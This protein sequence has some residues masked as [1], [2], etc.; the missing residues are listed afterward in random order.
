MTHIP[1]SKAVDLKAQTVEMF[2][3]VILYQ[4]SYFL[5]FQTSR[6]KEMGL[7]IHKR[8]GMGWQGQEKVSAGPRRCL[9]W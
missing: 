1:G 6:D 4:S 2:C 5:G 7:V 8:I 3:N 9:D